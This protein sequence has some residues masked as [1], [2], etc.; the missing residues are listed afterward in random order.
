MIVWILKC[1]DFGK[2][3]SI[4][5]NNIPIGKGRKVWNMDVLVKDSV[6]VGTG[7]FDDNHIAGV[8]V[9]PAY[10]KQGFGSYIMDCL[11]TEIW[12]KGIMA[13]AVKQ[14]CEYAS[15]K[16]NIIR[17]YVEPTMAKS[18]DNKYKGQPMGSVGRYNLLGK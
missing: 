15:D 9:L 5:L 7:C 1:K 4:L 12:G 11:E 8:Y 13:E 14:I 17:I 3:I 18:W 16:S 10:Q 6:I 2:K